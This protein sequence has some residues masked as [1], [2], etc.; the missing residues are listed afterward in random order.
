MCRPA[1]NTK[2]QHFFSFSDRTAHKILFLCQFTPSRIIVGLEA[3]AG[4][5]YFGAI[6]SLFSLPLRLEDDPI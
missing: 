2:F 4:G 5:G 1:N 6:I 3:G